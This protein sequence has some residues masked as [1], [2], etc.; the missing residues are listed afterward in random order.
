MP[1]EQGWAKIR[2]VLPKAYAYAVDSSGMQC[3]FDCVPIYHNTRRWIPTGVGTKI[4][5]GLVPTGIGFDGFK[6]LQWA[7]DADVRELQDCHE[8]RQGDYDTNFPA[9]NSQ[10]PSTTA[11]D[12]AEKGPDAF[13]QAQDDAMT[14]NDLAQAN[15]EAMGLAAPKPKKKP[16]K[17]QELT[18]EPATPADQQQEAMSR[19]RRT[20]VDELVMALADQLPKTKKAKVQ[21]LIDELR[22]LMD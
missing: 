5:L 16:A 7:P 21:S 3:A 2:E 10:A 11:T 19:D 4:N 6:T 1:N 8:S 20:V 17:T 13:G 9:E 14:A 15:L 22:D 12:P 18:P